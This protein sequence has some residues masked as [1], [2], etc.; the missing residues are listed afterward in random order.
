ML[1]CYLGR[2]SSNAVIGLLSVY[3]PLLVP[4]KLLD[5]CYKTKASDISLSGKRISSCLV[6][7]A[8]AKGSS[9]CKTFSTFAVH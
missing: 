6:H 7:V 1:L 8:Y 5:V 4:V 3:L 2:S 9:E